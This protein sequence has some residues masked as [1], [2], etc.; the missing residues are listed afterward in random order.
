MIFFEN[1]DHNHRP[2]FASPGPPA[3]VEFGRFGTLAERQPIR[4]GSYA[5]DVLMALIEPLGAVVGEDE[6]LRLVASEPGRVK[7]RNWCKHQS[8]HQCGY[9]ALTARRA[10]D[11]FPEGRRGLR[12]T[13]HD[14]AA[15]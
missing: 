14:G 8:L 5:L 12:R 6:L 11:G 7:V 15:L 3:M 9:Q 4:P 13:R 10:L 1:L 2:W